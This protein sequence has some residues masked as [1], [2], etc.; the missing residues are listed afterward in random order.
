MNEVNPINYTV[1][2][3][4]NL[5]TVHLFTKNPVESIS[6][7]VEKDIKPTVEEGLKLAISITSE[8][9]VSRYNVRIY[10]ARIYKMP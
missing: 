2:E 9:R 5:W 3:R 1:E 10:P 7:F 8:P 6:L 4:S